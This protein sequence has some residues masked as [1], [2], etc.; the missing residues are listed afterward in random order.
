MEKYNLLIWFIWRKN[1]K[2]NIWKNYRHFDSYSPNFRN[3]CVLFDN[4]NTRKKSLKEQY[5]AAIALLEKAV[6]KTPEDAEIWYYLGW[7]NH[8]LASDSR[9]L[10]G[11][12]YLTH[13]QKVFEYLNEAIRLNPQYGD[14]L[15]F[16]AA[17]CGTNVDLI[18]TTR[19]PSWMQWKRC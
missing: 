10:T 2:E 15:Y 7:F 17:E 19:K 16:Y 4:S 12:D 6:K 18:K 13:S 9:P 1:Y 5:H 14:A 3:D 8:Y 11:C